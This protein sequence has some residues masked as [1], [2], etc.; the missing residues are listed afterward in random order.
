MIR[1]VIVFPFFLMMSFL[2]AAQVTP[3]ARTSK[4]KIL[5]GEP[6]ILILELRAV[7]RNATVQ[8]KLPDS[9]KHFEY[10]SVDTSDLLER[11]ITL[12]SFDSG[13]WKIENIMAV[14]PSNI[15]NK[16]TIVKFPAPEM[17]VEYDT[18]G[19]QL[20]NDI[21][22]I[23]EVEGGEKWI[24][25]AVVTAAILSLIAL[26]ILFRRW[27]KKQVPVAVVEESKYSPLEEFM[28][29]INELKQNAWQSQMEQKRGFSD[30][31]FAAKR[32]FERKMRQ[33]FTKQTT[34]EM[35]MQLKPYLI[36]DRLF[37]ITQAL[38]MG[39]AVKFAKYNPSA[40]DCIKT[41]EELTGHIQKT[42]AELEQM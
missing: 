18:T 33:P 8:W 37:A 39:D 2:C 23:I 25:Y 16:P 27:R 42:D 35:V 30:L 13:L 6:F 10:I 22:P 32:Y 24:G 7:D 26:I 21:K 3:A 9:L 40:A 4:Q 20:L 11:K 12:T 14:V 31:S 15:N 28:Q 5:I 38:L 41:V 36:N 34:D 29:H 1:T 17:M 19:S